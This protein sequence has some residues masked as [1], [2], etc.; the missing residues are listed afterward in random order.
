MDPNGNVLPR[1]KSTLPNP[2]RVVKPLFVKDSEVFQPKDSPKIALPDGYDPFVNLRADSGDF[3]NIVPR[4][5]REKRE[6]RD[7]NE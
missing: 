4:V 2:D 5:K 6:Q 7:D 3:K 1:R